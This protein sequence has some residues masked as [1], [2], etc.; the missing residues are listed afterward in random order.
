[1]DKEK[2]LITFKEKEV[3]RQFNDNAHNRN[4]ILKSRQHGFTTNACIDGLDDVLFNRNFK[5][6]I[7]ADTLEHA[8][9]IFEK[10]QIAWNNFPLK[11]LYQADSETARQLMFNNG[12]IV[13]VTT[14][15]R[16][17]TVNRL[18]I[19]ELGPIADE[20]PKKAK[21]IITGSIPAVPKNGRIDIEST[22]RGETGLFYDMCQRA[23]KNTKIES[24]LDFKFHFFGW[25]EDSDC[26]LD[27]EFDVPQDLIA[28]QKKYGI[29]DNRINWYY[30]QRK[31]LG[32]LIKQEYPLNPEE[33]FMYSGQKMFDQEIIEDYLGRAEDGRK[34][35]NWTY[36][37]E[38]KP[39]HRYGLGADVSEG[40]G[41]DSNTIII[42][43][44]TPIKPKVVA[45]YNNNKIAPDLFAYEIKNGGEKYGMAIAGVE[46]NNPGHATITELK[47]IYPI[48]NIYQ[49]V[50][51]DRT[52]DL[53]TKILG[54][55]TTATTKPKMLY[56]L[57]RAVHDQLVEI[58]SKPLLTE[59]RTYDIRDLQV[60]RLD[61][62]QTQHWDL[63]IAAAIG[64]QMKTSLE[65]NQQ[66][67]SYR[68]HW[69]GYGKKV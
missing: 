12:S 33:A 40:L 30:Q 59:M 64:F 54:W 19:S 32:E 21:E 37:K 23:M 60:V 49:Y 17:A 6:T 24:Q 62:E 26:S 27:G 7:I 31:I 55:N 48:K 10:I 3:Q 61:E 9:E 67:Q 11:S 29:S 57:R 5:F 42:W 14:S 51:T 2:Q 47:K 16:S 39:G 50:R 36:Y 13:R 4:I 52:S 66:P 20:Q 69:T 63:L 28:Y 1:V 43:D 38:Y 22:A 25:L 18:H 56:D 46:K 34:E 44:F 41:L 35:G 65:D 45:C 15:A 8:K 58:P 68:P 53:K